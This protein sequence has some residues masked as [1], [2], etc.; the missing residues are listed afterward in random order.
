MKSKE[1]KLIQ[2]INKKYDKKLKP[3]EN[4][5]QIF[6]AYNEISIIEIKIRDVVYDTHYIQVDKFYNLLMAGEGIKKKIIFFF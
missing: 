2:E 1:L 3:T 6:D 4:Q 5:Y